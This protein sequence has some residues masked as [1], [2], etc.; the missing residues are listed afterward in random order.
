M[1]PSPVKSLTPSELAA[2]AKHEAVI[3]RG[4]K[5]F[6]E[7]GTALLAIRDGRL[8]R[9]QY[10]TFEQYCQGQWKMT[11]R[12]AN[13]LAAT[14]VALSNLSPMGDKTAAAARHSTLG[15]MVPKTTPAAD[16]SNPLPMEDKGAATAGNSTSR[17]M[18][19][20]PAEFARPASAVVMPTNER[21]V[22][23]LTKLPPAE[24][25]KA[26]KAAVDTAKS[27]GRS[28]TARDVEAEVAKRIVAMA[29]PRRRK[30]KLPPSCNGMAFADMAIADLE[31]IEDDDQ[32]RDEAFNHVKKWI[33][34]HYTKA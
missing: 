19:G 5:T 13:H 34:E 27:A 2:L 20:V 17:P 12:H 6:A 9:E 32:E 24:Q 4:L 16:P 29:P 8:Y 3:K 31:Q 14:A 18:G 25:P 1:N 26:W 10:A 30:I 7:V 21:Q 15:T 11:S 33:H 22:R 23:P 28:V